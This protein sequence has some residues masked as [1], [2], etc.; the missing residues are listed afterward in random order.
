M[1]GLIEGAKQKVWSIANDVIGAKPKP[2]SIRI[3]LV[4]Y[5]DKGDEYVTK[6]FDLTDDIDTVYK[7]L[8]TFKAEGGG[9]E[10]ESVNQALDDAVEKVSWSKSDGVARIIFLVGDAPP[11]MDYSD[12]VKYP[13]VCRKAVK[14]NLII[15]TVQCGAI[16]ATGPVWQEIAHRGEGS[17]VQLGQSG[18]MVAIATPMDPDLAVLNRR[19][20]QTL[21]VYGVGGALRP[22]AAT[23]Q[24]AKQRASEV[25]A[26]SVAADRLAY[27]VRSGKAVQGN[28]ELIDAIESK[29]VVLKDLK[30][31]Q[32]PADLRALTPEQ[33]EK[34]VKELMA[35]R[36]E[37]RKKIVELS[38]RR[39]EYIVA[40]KKKL[41]AA[42]K[43][44]SFDVE[45]GKVVSEEIGRKK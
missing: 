11:H 36:A 41:T 2:N 32:L 18:D 16:S 21:V 31:D 20:G 13:E 44:D 29:R 19:M 43:G 1:G 7:N 22:E 10:P 39:D 38:R 5:R 27:N 37:I 24:A 28:D 9:D 33:R 35:E 3:A 4:P 14:K 17:Y 34:R 12:D 15:N 40:E 30:D 45:V 25:A 42:G 6:V 26:A 23:S 8:Q